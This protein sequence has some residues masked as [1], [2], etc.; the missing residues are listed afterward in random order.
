MLLGRRKTLLVE[1]ATGPLLFLLVAGVYLANRTVVQRSDSLWTLHIAMSLVREGNLD[2]NEYASVIPPGDLRVLDINGRLVSHYPLGAPILVAPALLVLHPVV[3]LIRH[4]D[5]FQDVL[6]NEDPFVGLASDI[7]T[8]LA[9]LIAALT[10]VV[11]Y[12]S[13]RL[14]LNR[15]GAVLLTLVFA[16]GTAAWSTASRGLWQHGP[17]MLMLALALYFALRA[18]DEPRWIQ[19]AGLPLAFSYVCRPTN[20]VPVLIFTIFVFVCYRPYALRYCLWASLIAIPFL[21]ESMHLYGTFLQPYY[22]PRHGG[23][24]PLIL[25]AL[26]GNLVSPARGLFIYS[27]IFLLC[28]YGVFIWWRDGR[29]GSLEIV[30]TTIVIGHWLA[31]SVFAHWPQWWGG[32]SYGPRF[33]ADVSPFLI[34]MLAPVV[35]LWQSA[36]GRV[37]VPGIALF[38]LLF[39]VS[40]FMHYR[41]ATQWATWQWSEA[42]P[43]LHEDV[44]VDPSRLWDWSD[45][46]FLAGMEWRLTQPAS[47]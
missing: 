42:Q 38:V 4:V 33:F 5:L 29:F 22:L 27:P 24:Q 37:A 13:M 7:E 26:I 16:F 44:D 1:I 46:Q 35:Q 15:R 25:D 12:Y 45:P 20:A 39:A 11:I 21:L 9:S 18:R 47:Q 34:Y 31:I 40:A 32:A 10:A 14:V 17:S 2:L 41:G 8:A 3:R 43:G 28:G 23:G 19:F 36:T 6:L 30:V